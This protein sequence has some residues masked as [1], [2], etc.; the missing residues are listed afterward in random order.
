MNCRYFQKQLA[1]FIGGELSSKKEK[2]VQ[3][4]LDRCIK[5]RNHFE[6]LRIS[7][8]TF[9]KAIRDQSIPILDTG[10][11]ENVINRIFETQSV[12]AVLSGIRRPKLAWALS[13]I[14]VA[15]VFLFFL[16]LGDRF[17]LKS[18]KDTFTSPRTL[19]LV[20][21]AE[22][23]VTVMTFTTDDPKI[24]IVW[25]FQDNNQDNQNN[26]ENDDAM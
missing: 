1:L 18:E 17:K 6:S 8:N 16:M 7:G 25:F 20:E 26:K 5:C 9:S 21:K 14:A 3:D 12:S 23:G 10:F 11:T 19:P 22:P 13:A 2:V 15:V 24:T 4:H